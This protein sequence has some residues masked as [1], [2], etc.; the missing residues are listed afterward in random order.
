MW[1]LPEDYAVFTA[2]LGY[3]YLVFNG[4]VRKEDRVVKSYTAQADYCCMCAGTGR[5]DK[6]LVTK[7]RLINGYAEDWMVPVDGSQFPNRMV[8]S[9]TPR[10]TVPCMMHGQDRSIPQCAAIIYYRLDGGPPCPRP[11]A[12]VRQAT[13]FT[14]Y[15]IKTSQ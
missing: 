8:K 2:D 10:N 6:G 13:S 12:C 14:C 1:G 3:E 9:M 11:H 7:D 4:P 15:V 5:D